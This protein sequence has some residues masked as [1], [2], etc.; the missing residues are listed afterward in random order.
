MN[1]KGRKDLQRVMSRRGLL[2]M[3]GQLALTGLLGGRLYQLQVAQNRRY[4]GLSD[5]NQ[6]D[7]RIVPPVRG[8]VYDQKMRLLAGNAETF[9]LRITPLYT[10]NLDQ[11]LALLQQI[12]ELNPEQISDVHDQAKKGPSF[13]EIIVRDDLS[14][15][16]L[17]R[18]AVR[19]ALLG[20]VSFGKSLRRIYPQG[21]LGC[22]VTGYVSPVTVRELEVDQSLEQTP[23]LGTGKTGIERAYEKVLRGFPGWERIE[24]NA[25]GRAIRVFQDV[26]PAPGRDLQL[27][28]D[29]EVQHHAAETLRRGS[30]EAV[31][32][33]SG[34]AQRA[35]AK[36][37][38]LQAHLALG[39]D[40]I[41]RDQ[42]DRLVPPESGAAVVMDIQTGAVRA[43]VSVPMYD[44]NLFTGRLLSRDWQRLNN[45][46]RTPLLNRALSG[47]YAPGSTFKMVVGLAALEAGVISSRTKFFCGG[48]MTLGTAKFHCW[49]QGGHGSVDIIGALEQSCDVFFYEIALKTGIKKI[50]D[51]ANRLGLGI[52]TGLNLPGERPGIIPSH[53][54][55]LENRGRVWTPGETVVAGIGQGYVLSTPLQLAVMTARIANGKKAVSPHLLSSSV[56]IE[57]EFPPLNISPEALRIIR[58]GMREVMYGPLGTARK[59]QL[60]S[61]LGGMA[62]K[63]GTVQVKRIT[64][65]QREAGI[66]QNIDRPWAERDHALFVAY[67][68]V[69]KPRYA[70]SVV[71]EH[72]GSGSAAA[73]PVARDILARTITEMG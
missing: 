4:Q 64:K 8:R 33:G 9:Q 52:V 44:P 51:M 18:L 48:S 69:R 58:R 10:E 66:T 14:Q 26:V 30:L 63:T 59:H 57:A 67:A 55:K 46:P 13:Q 47:Q 21:T 72:G 53:E 7:M 29:M 42:K 34:R 41:L 35:I 17:A 71:V 12:I 27:S 70:I 38:D 36:N 31:P 49:R 11:T 50:K 3:A 61:D 28:I 22:H 45:H 65:A 20:G 6:F 5:R 32:M 37:P 23:N 43:M 73:A 39:D 54:W 1:R 56:G 68:P 15:R 25:K 16:E 24:V 2:L 60:G 62:G 19:S 40:L